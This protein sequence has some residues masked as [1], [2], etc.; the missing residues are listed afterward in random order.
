[1]FL[2]SN[3]C[4]NFVFLLLLMVSLRLPAQ[5]EVFKDVTRIAGIDF[6]HTDGGSQQRLFN[7]FLGAGGGF[8]DYD[9]DG[10]LDLYLMNGAV[11]LDHLQAGPKPTNALYRNNGDSTFTE[12]TERAN[13]EDPHFGLGCAVGDYDNDGDLDLYL[14]NFGPNQLYQNNGD[15]TFTNRSDQSGLADLKFSTSCAWADV[16][17]DGFLDL[18]VANYADYNPQQDKRCDVRGTWVYCGPR[19]YPPIS[20][21]FYH[22]NRNGTFSDWL[23]ESGLNVESTAHGLGVTFADYDNDAD[24]DLYVA[25]DQDANFL[26]QNLGDGKFEEIALFVGVS[27][28]LMGKEEAGMGT[29]FGDFNNDGFLDL[30]VS[31]FQEETNTLYINEEGVFFSDVT[32]TT[33]VAKPTQAFLGWG[34]QFFDYDNDGLKDIY[35]ANGHVMDNINQINANITLAQKNL[36]L[37][38]MGNQVFQPVSD[39]TGLALQKVSRAAA[40]GDYDND[41]DIDI[42]VT[43]WNQQPDLL[44]NQVGNRNNWIQLDL[45]GIT[46][47]RSAIGAKVKLVTDKRTQFQEV[48]SGGSYLA[49]NDLRVHFGLAQE[50]EIKMLEIRWPSGRIDSWSAVVINQRYLATEGKEIVKR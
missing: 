29:A 27:H 49:F 8:F 35:V 20:D 40:F 2:G 34:I 30:T 9:N 43:N 47:N 41:G 10:D 18:Y 42:L 36:L 39:K 28:G 23:S 12:I 24:L 31:N 37:R 21:S 25:N 46:S 3:A 48:H 44:Q 16:D 45:V 4:V 7:E 6:L 15:G 22:N 33:G 50:T 26:F 32:I 38:N 19:A 13:I 17:N 5:V 14:T 1:M 11:Q